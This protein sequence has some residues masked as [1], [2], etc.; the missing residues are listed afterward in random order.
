MN[1]PTKALTI[2]DPWAQAIIHGPKRVENRGQRLRKM[3]GQ[4]VAI[5]VSQTVDRDAWHELYDNRKYPGDV[6]KYEA[7]DV[8]HYPGHIIGSVRLVGWCHWEENHP[9][10]KIPV[11]SESRASGPS[12]ERWPYPDEELVQEYKAEGWDIFDGQFP[13]HYLPPE[14]DPWWQGPVGWLLDDVIEYRPVEARGMPGFWTIYE[15]VRQRLE[16]R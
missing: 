1:T 15:G 9:E 4:R 11:I 8:L 14:E 2:R 12:S 5:H 7:T 16:E 10:W 6:P 13:E 3:L